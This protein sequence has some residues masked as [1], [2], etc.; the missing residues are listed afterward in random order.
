MEIWN[1]DWDTTTVDTGT[2]RVVNKFFEL[3]CLHTVADVAKK[4]F[5]GT[6]RK[7]FS[8]NSGGEDAR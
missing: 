8:F 1:C 6:R 4:V 7:T 5:Y 2:M 3:L